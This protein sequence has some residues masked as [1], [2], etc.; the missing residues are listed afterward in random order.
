MLRSSCRS[1]RFP[2]LAAIAVAALVADCTSAFAQSSL[3]SRRELVVGDHPVSVIAADF[4][5][6][7]NLDLLSIDQISSTMTLIKGFGDGSFRKLK[8]ILAGSL[9]SAAAYVDVNGS[10]KYALVAP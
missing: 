7:G 4:D 5:E 6:D 2:A 9:P 8:T 1:K 3:K 10:T